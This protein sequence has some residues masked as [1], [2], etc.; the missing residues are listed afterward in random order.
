MIGIGLMASS[1]GGNGIGALESIIDLNGPASGFNFDQASFEEGDPPVVTVA[2]NATI[3]GPVGLTVGELTV[4]ISNLSDTGAEILDAD[5]TGTGITKD[6][7]APTLTLTGS[8]TL[9][10]FQQVL[11]TV[12]YSNTSE[13]PTAG[14][15]DLVFAATVT[16]AA[17]NTPS[18]LITVTGVADAPTIDLNGAGG[19]IDFS[20]TFTVGGAAVEIA[21]ATATA[22]DPDSANLQSM[23]VTITNI[24]DAGDEVLDADVGATGIGKSYTAPTLTLT[25]PSSVANFQQ[26]LRTITYVNNNVT[27]TLGARTI[28]VV[29]SDGALSSPVATSTV[30]VQEPFTVNAV[31]FDGTNDYLTKAAQLTGAADGGNFAISLWFQSG[32]DATPRHFIDGAANLF[33][34][35]VDT[36]NKLTGD[37]RLVAGTIS[38]Q[39]GS[40]TSLLVAGGW[41]HILVSYTS[42]TQT[43]HVYIDDVSETLDFSTTNANDMDWT[44]ILRMFHLTGPSQLMNG[45]I[46]EFWLDDNYIDFSVEANRRKFIGSDGKPVNLGAN[47]ELPLGAAPLVFFSGATA[48]WHT[49]KG[50]GGGFTENGALTDA[51]TSPS[52]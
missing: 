22:V 3:T 18:S 2:A 41:Y 36:G 42:A 43:L 7:V 52:D 16:S 50:T 38:F 13:N 11:R 31:N 1:A 25:G 37:F 8:G 4:T 5:V 21:D 14:T 26:V 48:D 24:Q 6:Y 29:A 39:F 46:A 19:G 10:E 51:T 9:A 47:G 30:D 15:R 33:R 27:P 49:N 20:T 35:A 12:T 34:L 45:D 32:A 17:S 23:T 28:E 44:Q 40:T